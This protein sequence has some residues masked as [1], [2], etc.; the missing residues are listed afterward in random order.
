[1][2][3]PAGVKGQAGYS[4]QGGGHEQGYKQE[5]VMEKRVTAA[6]HLECVPQTRLR[7]KN[8]MCIRSFTPYKILVR[9][10]LCS[11]NFTKRK[12]KQNR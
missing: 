7:S 3:E 12:Q 8:C 6:Q 5:T 10:G 4:R 11:F 9:Q 2:Q 1:M